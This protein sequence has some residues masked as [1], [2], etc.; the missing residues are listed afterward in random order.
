MTTA[1]QDG[2]APKT[3]QMIADSGDHTPIPPGCGVKASYARARSAPMSGFGVAGMEGLGG[4][5]LSGSAGAAQIGMKPGQKIAISAGVA[6]GLLQQRTIPVYPPVAKAAKVSGTVVLQAT[7]SKEGEV[8][9]LRVVSGPPLLQ[10][11]AMDAVKQWKYRPFL[12]AGQPVEIE[13][14]VN[15]V[16]TLGAGAAPAAP[17]AVP[18]TQP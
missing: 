18:P 16:F 10:Q 13:T 3:I 7:I 15:V 11:S 5:A 14:T 4:G 8:T 12:V 6:V 2:Q 9:D 17:Q 1:P